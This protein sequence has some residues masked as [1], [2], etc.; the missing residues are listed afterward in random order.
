MTED[1]WNFNEGVNREGTSAAKW[2][3]EFL[4][5]YF[6][7]EDVL[8]LWV[9]DM[10]FK[11]PD[12]LLNALKNRID[13][14]V[15]GYTIAP[16][17]YFDAI[18]DW[19]KRK[20]QWTIEKDWINFA[21]G[22]VPAINFIVQTFT[23]PGDKII[24]QEPVYYPF[25]NQVEANGRIVINNELIPKERTYEIDF[26]DLEKKCKEERA[27]LFI[28][29]SPHNP[30][31]RVWTKDELK[32]M[33][34]ICLENNVLVIPDE[35]HCDLIFPG[36][37]HIPFAKISEKFA[38]NSITCVA[39]SKTFNIAGLKT[40]YVIIPNEKL[41]KEFTTTTSNLSIR[42]P[43]I[44][45]I[46]ATKAVYNDCEDW[47]DDLLVYM[48]ANFDYLK[49]Y[50][51]SQFKEVRVFDLEGTY[52]PWVD[53]RA[54]GIDPKKLDEII[55]KDAKVLLDDGKM[56]GE[57]GAGFQRFNIACPRKTLQAAVEQI[58]KAIKEHLA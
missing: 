20:H 8:P 1:K 2:D 40:S 32:R 28:L 57:H 45:G 42:G 10:D 5:K 7:V 30:V 41:R 44:I 6:K 55:K 51:E 17:S 3:Q 48:K 25:K 39:A 19:F 9:A 31:C 43:G 14:G 23:R 22:V 26:D 50:F 13:H 33:G 38:Q 58:T 35:I 16:D 49:E 56:F 54:L 37:K 15:F 27:K 12:A 18:I 46:E 4:K 47:L 29:C 21:P 34:E 36:H 24:I 52:L 53:F 11:A